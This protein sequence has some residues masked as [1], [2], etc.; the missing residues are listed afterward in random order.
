MTL[1]DT[2]VLLWNMIKLQ[3]V[4]KHDDTIGVW[5]LYHGIEWLWYS[6]MMIF[7]HYVQK[8]EKTVIKIF[9]GFYKIPPIVL[10][11]KKWPWLSCGTST[12]F[13]SGVKIQWYY[14]STLGAKE[15]RWQTYTSILPHS[16]A[17]KSCTSN[18]LTVKSIGINFIQLYPTHLTIVKSNPSS[19]PTL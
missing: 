18:I 11:K 5:Y 1:H 15:K 7:E 2:M 3:F 14:Y 8:G 13:Y 4:K 17:V 12:R 9:N 6:Y 16:N 10:Q 19:S